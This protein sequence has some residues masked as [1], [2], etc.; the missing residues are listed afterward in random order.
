M[1]ALK[2]QIDPH[3]LQRMEEREVSESE[4]KEVLDSGELFQARRG[5]KGKFKVL[6]YARKRLGKYY[7]Q[8][9]VEVI[10]MEE[11]ENVITIT[12]YAYFG[13]WE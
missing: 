1:T 3:T 10:Y 11:H 4:V 2:I 6:K 7:P 12:V 8:K 9:K 5:R 13:K